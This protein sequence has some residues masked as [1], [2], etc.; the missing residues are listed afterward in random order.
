MTRYSSI[1]Y[2]LFIIL[3]ILNKILSKSITFSY[4][5]CL[6]NINLLHIEQYH[7]LNSQFFRLVTKDFHLHIIYTYENETIDYKFGNFNFSLPY[8]ASFDYQFQT[9]ID[10]YH[11]IDTW[12]YVNITFDD[13]QS[14]V[15]ISFN[16]DETRLIPLINYRNKN[17][18]TT[19]LNVNVLVDEQQT[20]VTCLLPY[21]G[22][23]TNYQNCLINIKTCEYQTC[24]STNNAEQYC[25]LFKIFD[26]RPF[27]DLE[28]GLK[29]IPVRCLTNHCQNRGICYVDLLRNLTQCV[30]PSGFA[31][32]QCQY[33]IDECQS[34]PCPKHSH[35]IDL[36]NSYTCV[37]DPGWTGIDC[38][39]DIDECKTIQPCK[40]ARTCINLPGT[41]KCDC[42]D[43]F[44]GQ[45]CE[46][47]LDPCL[48]QPCLND[49]LKC[50]P[51]LES[52]NVVFRCTCQAGFTG[53]RCETNI[54]DCE[55]IICPKNNTY[56]I[57]GLNSFDCQCKSNFKRNRDGLC[58]E[59]NPC[60]SSPCHS[61]ATCYNLNGGEYRCMCPPTYT[62]IRCDQ[63][64]D[65]CSV[66][67][68]I[69]RN[70]GTCVNEIGSYRCYCASGWIGSTCAK[71]IDY[72]LSQPCNQNGTCINKINGFECR[73]LST[74]TGDVCQNDI[75]ECLVN[76][77]MNNG[78]CYNYMGD[79]HCKCSTGYYGDH[80]E[81]SPAECQRLQQANLS[82]KC[83]DPQLCIVNDTEKLNQIN[84]L[85]SYTCK[86]ERTKILDTYFTCIN[87][88]LLSTCHCPSDLISCTDNH[89]QSKYCGC[90]NGGTCF[91]TNS[92]NYRCYC[93]PGLTGED[94]LTDIN[95]CSSQPCYNNGTCFPHLN[96]FTCQCP[97]Y[98]K[99]IYCQEFID[100]CEHNPC[101]NNGQCQPIN[102]TYQCNCTSSYIGNH[103]E[104]YQTSCLSQPCQNHGQC[105]DRNNN[106]FE[107][108]CPFNY[109][110]K[111]CEESIDLCKTT[112]NTS[113]CLNGGLCQ[114]MNRT[115]QCICLP[116]FTGLFCDVNIDECY[117]KPC[118]PHGECLDLINGYQ[119]QCKSGYYG[120]NCDRQQKELSK[121][122]IQIRSSLSSTFHLRNSSINISKIL[123][124]RSSLI[125]I[126]IQY[127]FRTTLKQISL[128]AIGKRFQ[129]ELISNRI[130]TNLDNKIMLS[131]FIDNQDQ[132]IM[133]IIEVYQLWIDVRIGKNSMSQRFYIRNSS[134]EYELQKEIIF[135]YR[136]Y[137]GCIRQVEISY[138]Q[139]YSILLTDQ[140]V[141]MNENTTIGCHRTNAC[142]TAV[143]RKNELCHD[144][145]FYY[146][147]QCQSPFFGEQCDQIAPIVKF[148]QSS[149]VDI[150]SSS[151]ISNISF[152]FNT[153]QSNGTL[154][155]LF[156]SSSS[157][158]IRFTRDITS[159]NRSF[160]KILGTLVNG[161]FHLIVIDNEPKS[162][163]YELRNEQKLDDGHPHQIQLDLNNN[164]LI[165]DGIYNE[166][167][168]KLNH[169]IIPDKLQLNP[170]KNLSGWLQDLRINNQLISLDNTSQ[171]T[172]DLNVTSF[173]TEK[174]ENNPCYPHNP[175]QNQGTCLVTN[176][177]DYLCQCES[178]WFGQNCTQI[179]IC[180]N[181]NN[182][183]L[184]PDG[185]ICKTID[186]NNQECLATGTFEGNSSHLIGLFNYSSILTNELSFHLRAHVQSGH[187]LTIKNLLNSKYFSFYLS[188][189]NLIYRD[190]SLSN[191]LIIELNNQTFKQWTLFHFQ[192][193]ENSTLIFNYSYTYSI[194]ITFDEI[195]LLNDQIELTIGNGFRGCLE[196]VLLGDN[197]YVPFYKDLI[198][199]NNN[200][201]TYINR[202][203]IEQ[204]E[205]IQ[206]NNCSFTNICANLTCH[207]GQCIN[208]FDRGK[209][210]CNHGWEGDY[211]E[212][213]ID[214]CQQGNNCSIEH[215]TCEDHIDGYYTCKCQ[216]GFTG[217]YCETNIDEC[218]SSPCANHGICTDLIN[219]YHCNC[220]D[221]YI[222]SN[223]SISLNETCFGRLKPCQNNGT[224][225]LKS[226][227]LYVDYPETECQCHDGYNGQWCENDLCLKLN[228]QHN[229]TCQRLSNGQAKCLCTEQWN[230]TECQT[231]V[232]E[233]I[234]N[235]TNLCLN[236]GTCINYPGG[237][238]CHCSENYL[239]YHCERKHICLEHTPCFNNGQ[240]R[241]D[242]EN[243]Y[244]ECSSNFTGLHCEF[245]TCESAPC[246]NNGTCIPDSERGFQ[247]NCTETGYEDEKCMTEINECLSNPC[248]NN[249]SCIDQIRGYICVCPKSFMGHQCQNKKFL[250]LLGFSYHYVIWPGI[251]ILLL[252]V[253]ILLTIVISRIRESRRSR[254]TYRP[255]LN[256]NG[257]SSRVEFSMILKPPPEERLI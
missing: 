223:C 249:G 125:P 146:T 52:D 65:E 229:G 54:N 102:N 252:L 202:I 110:G 17:F 75:D 77:C 58:V 236:N 71:A 245:P 2:F 112:S 231:D 115:I 12:H 225:I 254:G 218:S 161:R 139:A 155:E 107:C 88:Q 181:N 123:P 36:P 49:A 198:N 35:C 29:T 199:E 247:C 148:N 208:D 164:R 21:S 47:S 95:L 116:G 186:N 250:A 213:N 15:F 5:T 63:D 163:E 204:I 9:A 23:E 103:C 200:N 124:Y 226:T 22:F 44:G 187:L 232:N 30:C 211:C 32:N 194:N 214:E 188:G 222:S 197:L 189:E 101:L 203:Q 51:I 162:E 33:Q 37:C 243:Y 173:N 242:G 126:R 81:Y 140:L 177:H 13:Y 180:N 82:I 10:Y 227:N 97:T 79:F 132:W 235:K 70:G 143:C 130:V 190:S 67:P 1:Y 16:G 224:C 78:T 179:N 171:S 87:E 217:K 66:F 182:S 147:C 91:W 176:S 60:N 165:I 154:F 104:L 39:E 159:Q 212:K 57:D 86:T 94:C 169:K 201:N 149:L 96:T 114:I 24:T 144:H 73:C 142:E 192:W 193:L 221:N 89:L 31:G 93:P 92:T 105:F 248:Q 85:S 120:Y 50:H 62:G 184:C 98:T 251:A 28:C 244:C 158:S 207:N 206:I 237:Y 111:F 127:E 61:N 113:L 150:S 216:Q 117:T 72:C 118:S 80:C 6:P 64:I 129:Q 185:F 195:F 121:S 38:S 8:S 11:E 109:Q 41:Y 256:E 59:Q 138:S 25:P 175:C 257:Q 34:S 196:Y 239:G 45:N 40:A 55:G 183:S 172:N 246:R 106:T 137:S 233:C 14:K 157:K 122:L 4:R 141:E 234:M 205:N 76:P 133:I 219:G 19:K 136:N 108:Q 100:P 215:S 134:L 46:M 53:P 151:P 191:D 228:C 241:P 48:S 220:T 209:C 18:T 135:G 3:I 84:Q 170:D 99:G 156:S 167:L 238:T 128:L 90:Q 210:L 69:C 43:N 7:P 255:A 230:G 152:F 153:L 178:N 20:N 42:F 27:T 68:S 26:C 240:C 119:C 145:W 168:I 74:F 253:I 174:L 160:V 166:S 83:T 56:C 131:T